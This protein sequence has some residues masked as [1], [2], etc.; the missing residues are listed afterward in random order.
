MH[1]MDKAD[2]SNSLLAARMTSIA[3]PHPAWEGVKMS[4]CGSVHVSSH[5]WPASRLASISLELR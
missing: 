2:V 1:V 5:S 3:V 4:L